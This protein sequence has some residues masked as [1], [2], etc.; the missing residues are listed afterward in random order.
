M[1]NYRRVLGQEIDLDKKRGKCMSHDTDNVENRIIALL[2]TR[3]TNG[4]KDYG[5]V[6]DYYQIDTGTNAKFVLLMDSGKRIDASSALRLLAAQRRKEQKIEV[7]YPDGTALSLRNRSQRVRNR[8]QAVNYHTVS[9]IAEVNGEFISI[10][11]HAS[12]SDVFPEELNGRVYIEKRK[13]E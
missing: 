5:I 9:N 3:I 1:P 12:S 6:I 2:N 10:T 11:S 4:S 7:V 8:N 13:G